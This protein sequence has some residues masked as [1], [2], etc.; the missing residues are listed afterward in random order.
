MYLTRKSNTPIPDPILT[1]RLKFHIWF[2]NGDIDIE[3]VQPTY[4]ALFVQYWKSFQFFVI[5][6]FCVMV[7]GPGLVVSHN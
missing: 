1:S 6:R 3:A 4:I 2:K 5:L 7:K